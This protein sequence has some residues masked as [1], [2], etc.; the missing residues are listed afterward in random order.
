VG[1]K[2]LDLGSAHFGRETYDVEMDVPFDPAYVGLLGAI[3]VVLEA[4]GITDLIQ[5]L[6]GA[7]LFHGL[8]PPF[9]KERFRDYDIVIVGLLLQPDHPSRLPV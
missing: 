5:S 7:V 4:D 1:E 6:L 9:D 3:G 8:T 2:G